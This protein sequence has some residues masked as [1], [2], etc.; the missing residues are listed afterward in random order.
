MTRPTMR[1][2][3]S[4]HVNQEKPRHEAETL[5]KVDEEIN[6]LIVT[7]SKRTEKRSVP[8]MTGRAQMTERGDMQSTPGDV[9][10]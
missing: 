4:R 1:S 9:I 6:E 8:R 3:T 10:E 5:N 2:S 7:V